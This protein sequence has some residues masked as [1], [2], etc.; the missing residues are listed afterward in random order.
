MELKTKYN[1]GDEVWRVHH[2]GHPDVTC[3]PCNG[4]GFILLKSKRRMMCSVCYG[5]GHATD[6][7]APSTYQP[8]KVTI[9]EVKVYTDNRG[10]TI[11]YEVGRDR[12]SYIEESELHATIEEAHAAAAEQVAEE[13][14]NKE[15]INEAQTKDQDPSAE[16][17]EEEDDINLEALPKVLLEVTLWYQPTYDG[18]KSS[19]DEVMRQ[20]LTGVRGTDPFAEVKILSITNLRDP[21]A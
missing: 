21:Q 11:S 15:H 17:V 2:V 10:T 14:R 9:S 6:Y 16:T 19:R 3:E 8:T 4:K 5:A 18:E 1:V 20:L 12:E 7:A 13:I